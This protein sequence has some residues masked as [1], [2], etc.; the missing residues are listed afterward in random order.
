MTLDN[1][2]IAL[3]DPRCLPERA[4]DTD[5][6]LDVRTISSVT[7]PAR[8]SVAIDTGLHVDT[9]AG[10][11]VKVEDRS[12]LAFKHDVTHV[13]GIIDPGFTDTIKVKLVNLSDTDQH[14][15][16]YERVAQLLIQEVETPTL[17]VV[18]VEELGDSRGGFGSTGT[19]EVR[20]DAESDPTNDPLNPNHYSELPGGHENINLA[21]VLGFLLGN[22]EKYIARSTRTDG[23][24][25]GK[26]SEDLGKAEWYT[27]RAIGYLEEYSWEEASEVL[28]VSPTIHTNPR[29]FQELVDDICSVLTE[30]GKDAVR[31]LVRIAIHSWGQRCRNI[32]QNLQDDLIPA[33]KA[34]QEAL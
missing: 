21:E 10:H 19:V 8:G 25:K 23:H 34:C 29:E 26:R 32:A 30:E 6:G 31:T 13:A 16:Q 1:L 15:E 5:A 22:A 17:E 33:V 2:R 18:P 28:G 12:G 20:D 9:P 14:L 27:R 24:N 4:H 7:V 3:D 11:V